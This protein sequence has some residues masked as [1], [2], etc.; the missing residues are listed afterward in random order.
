MCRLPDQTLSPLCQCLRLSINLARTMTVTMP[1]PP[2]P[3][4]P[5]VV[6]R[7]ALQYVAFYNQYMVNVQ[8]PH[9]QPL[10]ASR[11]PGK[12]LL[13][14]SAVLPVGSTQDISIPR[15]ETEGPEVV[16]R[17]FTPEGDAPENGWP[18]MLYYHGGGW[19]LGSIDSENQVCTN[20][21][22]RSRC[23]VITP[24]YR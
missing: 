20:M 6:N 4:H 9:H 2:Y 8:Q 1:Q 5:S 18:V 19:V 21:C 23:V 24:E 7:L 17:C 16:L 22:V 14:G 10:A 15:Q 3:L 11:L 12:I 13:A